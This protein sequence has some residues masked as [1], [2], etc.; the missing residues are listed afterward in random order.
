MIMTSHAIKRMKERGFNP[1]YVIE[2]LKKLD[3]TYLLRNSQGYEVILPFT[4]RLAGI[5]ENNAFVVKTFLLPMYNPEDY[6]TSVKKTPHSIPITVEKI[7]TPKLFW[8]SR[9]GS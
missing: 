3:E 9:E 4:G 5:I 1:K 8:E 6:N 7:L 2:R